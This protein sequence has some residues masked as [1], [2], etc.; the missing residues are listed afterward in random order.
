MLTWKPA[1]SMQK[2]AQTDKEINLVSGGENPACIQ[3]RTQQSALA[4]KVSPTSPDQEK[5][6]AQKSTPASQPPPR[7]PR[8]RD[9]CVIT[10]QNFAL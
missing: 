2:R 6:E 7:T 1:S 5:E 8:W 3:G 9:G 10:I 4:M